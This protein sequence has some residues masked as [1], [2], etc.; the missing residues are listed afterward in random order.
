MI[1]A[2]G[3]LRLAA[4]AFPLF[5]ASP[6]RAD[7]Q[8]LDPQDVGAVLSRA[9]QESAARHQP[10]TIA[11]VDRLGGVLAVYR[12]AGANPSPAGPGFVQVEIN[13]NG[14][15]TGLDGAF[16]PDVAAAISKA[17]APAYL[18]T[19]HGNAFSTR[20]VSQIVQDHFDP[21]QAGTP[22]GPLFGLQFSQLSCSDVNIHFDP[23]VPSTLTLGPHRAPLGFAAAPGGFPLYKNGEMVGAVGVAAT[24]SYG[25][26]LD[27]HTND[28]N[29]DEIIAL[30]AT[31]GL[32][33]PRALRADQ[34]TVGGLL[35]RYS[36]A[37]PAEFRSNPAA[38]PPFAEIPAAVGAL[39]SVTGYYQE[40]DGL[41]QG[42]VYGT[43]ASGLRPD[44]SGEFS[45]ILPPE[46]LVDENNA[47]RFPPSAGKETGALTAEET[48]A[49]LRAAYQVALQARSAIRQ[50]PGSPATENITVVDVEG[51]ILGYIA[52]PD[53][54]VDGADAA[55]QKART[56]V[57]VSR[58]DAAAALATQPSLAPFLTSV[59]RFY[60][61]GA[62]EN[63]IA[64]STR[65]VALLSR[66]TFPDGI[67]GTPNGPF[68]LPASSATPFSTGLQLGLIE[69]NFLEHVDFIL[70]K[71]PDT[72][73]PCTAL[74][75]PAGSVSGL[76]L[77]R[78]G[79]QIFAGGF[80]IYRDGMLVGGIGASGDGDDQ[81]DLTAFLGLFNAATS[82][83]TGLANAPPGIRADQLEA[84]GVEL[85]YVSC[86]VAPY[87]NSSV[88]NL[89]L[90][91]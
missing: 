59:R 71:G 66:D 47:P 73:V 51:N 6:A 25:L 75:A 16:V 29:V 30:A 17:V 44:T 19:T 54:L 5:A 77:L 28:G 23:A 81:S 91:K 41:R 31:I 61:A 49:I 83:H 58:R 50:P 8:S 76:P 63:G 13:P 87:L 88:Q 89:C 67:G 1:R 34:I 46:I 9:V 64:F 74:P 48:T 43:P 11:V 33:A 80:P 78:D 42:V 36:D 45:T 85:R 35:L 56:A 7:T 70:G 4:L 53:T 39:T 82:L 52:T 10:A 3:L 32:D 37:T 68:S 26:D 62:L 20:T 86:P 27:I 79:L 55:T 65:A 69:A 60:G 21:G 14:P 40:S 24:K 84:F 72:A 2:G 15:N 57:F 22:S 38:A 12:M 18:S 90:G